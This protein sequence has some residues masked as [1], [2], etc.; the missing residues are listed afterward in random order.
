[1]PLASMLGI[2]WCAFFG[3]TGNAEAKGKIGVIIMCVVLGFLGPVIIKFIQGA[4]L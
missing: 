4:L 2:A 1:M 3:F